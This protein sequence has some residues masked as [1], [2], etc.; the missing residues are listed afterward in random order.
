M[1]Y[2]SKMP[3]ECGAY[4]NP[5]GNEFPDSFPL[6]DEL[7][8]MFCEYNGFVNFIETEDGYDIEPRV[9]EW[10]EWRSTLPE[11]VEYDPLN[12]NEAIT[13]MAETIMAGIDETI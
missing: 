5:Q 9:E 1:W 11:P 10:K 6:K 13:F 7:V 4:S 12:N 2:V 3:T 8:P